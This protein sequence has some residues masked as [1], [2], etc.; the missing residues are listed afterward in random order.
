[1]Y[2]ILILLLS[3]HLF[4]GYFCQGINS[5][6]GL[7]EEFSPENFSMILSNFQNQSLLWSINNNCNIALAIHFDQE[8]GSINARCYNDNP[9][10]NLY[11]NTILTFNNTRLSYAADAYHVCLFKKACSRSFIKKWISWQ[12]KV[13]NE[14][15][16]TRTKKIFSFIKFHLWSSI[17]Q[18]ETDL[19]FSISLSNHQNEMIGDDQCLQRRYKYIDTR[20]RFSALILK[21]INLISLQS[22]VNDTKIIM[23]K[24][25]IAFNSSQPILENQ[26]SQNKSELQSPVNDTES[27]M[28]PILENQ[29]PPNKS[30]LQSPVNDTKSV[31]EPI[32]E[33][34]MPPNKSED[35]KLFKISLLVI[36][37]VLILLFL[38]VV[39]V[40]FIH[41]TKHSRE[42]HLTAT[43]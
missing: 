12:M 11:L 24:I 13:L 7:S 25:S 38:I 27:V 41:F 34:Q 43:S 35:K 23:E 17:G 14:M 9:S 6:D 32:L 21:L 29:M 1:M 8:K 30:E 19:C 10:H 20:N 18:N 26:M 33:K 3:A 40:S 42:Y 28:E 4:S 37:I 39:I 22:P 5:S 31:M 36:I 15:V 16:Q 2:F